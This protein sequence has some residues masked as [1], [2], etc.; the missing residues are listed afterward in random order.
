MSDDLNLS[1]SFNTDS[2][3][4]NTGAGGDDELYAFA[5]CEQVDLKTAVC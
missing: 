5:D 2:Q 3:G 1:Y 4:S